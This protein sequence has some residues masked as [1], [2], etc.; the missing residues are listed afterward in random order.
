MG[1]WHARCVPDGELSVR[2]LTREF[3]AKAFPRRGPVRSTAFKCTACHQRFPVP[4]TALVFLFCMATSH[5]I[6][7]VAMVLS[8]P[9]HAGHA[10]RAEI[11]LARANMTVRAQLAN[12]GELPS[13]SEFEAVCVSSRRLPPDVLMV[14]K[15]GSRTLIKLNE[16]PRY[17]RRGLI[18]LHATAY[19]PC[20]LAT[21]REPCERV[22]SVFKHLY[23]LYHGR[24][25]SKYCA[26]AASPSPV[27][28]AHWFHRAAHV[29]DFVDLLA[30]NWDEVLGHDMRNVVNSARHRVV[31]M[32]QYLWIGR[33]SHVVC[34]PRLADELPALARRHGCAHNATA[35][36]CVDAVTNA[37]AAP[38]PA[39]LGAAHD[40]PVDWR[41]RSTNASAGEAMTNLSHRS[42][43]AT[44]QLYARDAHLWRA[45]CAQH[46]AS[47]VQ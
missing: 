27:C 19:V 24:T 13:P 4:G 6:S 40:V 29:D 15:T 42:C 14:P 38:R 16:C 31:A 11:D 9:L 41:G 22:V 32:P 10:T 30:A 12:T 35:C 17:H 23:E 8:V 43:A 46:S 3:G 5:A 36:A 1:K 7:L 28:P 20:S 37:S 25:M 39:G 44:R 45:L 47:H 21:L 26:H 34:T 33:L 18:H 2:A